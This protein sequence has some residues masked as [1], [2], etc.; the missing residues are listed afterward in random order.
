MAVQKIP[1]TSVN[2]PDGATR[3]V[4]G[5]Y[6][7][8]G[9]YIYSSPL[10]AG[11]YIAQ[12]RYT[13]SR[14]IQNTTTTRWFPQF[15]LSGSVNGTILS[16]MS[17]SGFY[18]DR[19]TTQYAEVRDGNYYFNIPSTESALTFNGGYAITIGTT[20]TTWTTTGGNLDF[21]AFPKPD[22]TS[23]AMTSRNTIVLGLS[24][25]GVNT[26]W[27]PDAIA[28]TMDSGETWN[29]TSTGTP[30]AYSQLFPFTN[31]ISTAG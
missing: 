17:P 15:S 16:N 14:D 4:F 7:S 26:Y 20:V 27:T 10:P 19:N 8:T 12:I 6:S 2:G 23:I 13:T 21:V 9:T 31:N 3:L 30:R 18:Y 11:N 1:S 5:G 25:K 28:E 24:G 22:I 29:N